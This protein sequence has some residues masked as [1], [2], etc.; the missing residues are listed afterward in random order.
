MRLFKQ[1][2]DAIFSDALLI[3]LSLAVQSLTPQSDL[4]AVVKTLAPA[5]LAELAKMKPSSSSS[6]SSTTTKDSTSKSNQQKSEVS[7][8]SQ[9]IFFYATNEAKTMFSGSTRHN[10]V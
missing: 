2:N 10:T 7:F 5:L 3:L 9:N 4:E 8:K 1:Q 6:S